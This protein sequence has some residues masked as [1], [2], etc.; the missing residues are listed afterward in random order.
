M[1]PDALPRPAQRPAERPTDE[2]PLRCPSLDGALKA[3][4]TQLP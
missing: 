1:P 4:K 3:L 2:R